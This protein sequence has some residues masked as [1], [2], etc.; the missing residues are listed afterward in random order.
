MIWGVVFAVSAGLMWCGTG[1]IISRVARQG[2]DPIGLMAVTSLLSTVIVWILVPRYDVLAN[3][4]IPRLGELIFY[5]AVAGSSVSVGYL[6]L[7]AAMRKG[8]HGATFAICQSALVFPFIV[9]VLFWNSQATLWNYGGIASILLCLVFLGMAEGDG[10]HDAP[11]PG[12]L[13]W[14][15]LALLALVLTGTELILKEATTKWDNWDDVANIRIPISFTAGTIIYQVLAIA[16]KRYNRNMPFIEGIL[17]TALVIPSQ[18]LIFQALE[19]FSA[20]KLNGI[21]WPTAISTCI[22]SFSFYSIFILKE[23]LTKLRLTGLL[24][25]IVGVVLVA[26][27]T[28]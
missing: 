21:G 22:V 5:M 18:L 25:G 23:P 28:I 4:A 6:F 2:K 24:F 14:L 15:S 19:I 16:L 20:H 27:R 17:M 8:H 1:T 10:E 26:I 3:E 9:G 7:Q 12:R 11:E 13:I